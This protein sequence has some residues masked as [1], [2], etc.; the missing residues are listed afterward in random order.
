[1]DERCLGGFGELGYLTAANGHTLAFAI[2]NQGVASSA[3]G[4][5]FQDKVCIE[6]CK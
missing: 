5:A 3:I 1:M 4:R 6:L 2:I